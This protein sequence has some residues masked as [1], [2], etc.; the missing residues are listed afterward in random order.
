MYKVVSDKSQF[1]ITFNHGDEVSGIVNGKPFHLDLFSY[2]KG[3]FHI[4][5]GNKSFSA[6]ITAADYKEK[7]FIIRINGNKYSF[8]V[9]D[10]YDE[11]LDTLGLTKI[12]E[13][14]VNEI[15]APMPGLVLELL[16][17]Q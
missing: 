15:K 4:I 10:R 9:R 16:V 11:L 3:S 17:K 2:G 13:S 14:K 7:K 12:N 1:A 6:Q 8:L 5:K